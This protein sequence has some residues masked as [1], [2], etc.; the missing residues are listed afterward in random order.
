MS[1][2]PWFPYLV[3]QPNF[4]IVVGGGAMEG[5]T[6][7]AGQP[8]LAGGAEPE[9]CKITCTSRLMLKVL[10]VTNRVHKGASP[11]PLG[12]PLFTGEVHI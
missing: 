3:V 11:A 4:D 7:A 12:S 1:A 5:S 9:P 6:V 10:P 8:R 2:N